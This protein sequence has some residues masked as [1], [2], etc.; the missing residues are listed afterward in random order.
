M[1]K[2]NTELWIN[3]MLTDDCLNSLATNTHTCT[4]DVNLPERQDGLR[5]LLHTSNT[6]KVIK[7][8]VQQTATAEI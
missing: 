4:H 1:P 6:H 5:D 7:A 2:G 8:Q 3:K